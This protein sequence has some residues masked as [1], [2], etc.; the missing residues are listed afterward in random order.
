MYNLAVEANSKHLLRLWAIALL[1]GG[2]VLGGL[3]FGTISGLRRGDYTP[4]IAVTAGLAF[5]GFT[6]LRSRRKKLSL[7]KETTPDRAIA[8]YHSSMRR[9]PNAKGMVA[10]SS[11]FAAVLY[12]QFDRARE[13]LASVNWST[14]PPM[15]QGFE[16]YTH[17]LLA[18]FE[19]HDYS[20][21]LNLAEEARDL[22][23]V[24]HKFPGVR[25]SRAALDA[26]VAVCELLMG[27]N[28]SELLG[29]L[30]RATKELPG[31]S[32]AIPAWA[33]AVFYSKAGQQ[34]QQ[35][36]IW[37]LCGDSFRTVLP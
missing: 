3:V 5:A 7:F 32:P 11:A 16:V 22:C 4:V 24:S 29:S 26:N 33:L 15:Y 9:I 12:G 13:E 19:R 14:L 18:I 10:Y 1:F 6:V 28:S 35:K 8:S 36:N 37:Q 20:R 21:A 2:V 30:D 17:S 27:K 31:V 25:K 23:D 34:S